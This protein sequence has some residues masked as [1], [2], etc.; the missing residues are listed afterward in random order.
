MRAFG[1]DAS[2]SQP[3]R[4]YERSA[5]VARTQGVPRPETVGQPVAFGSP[6]VT[7]ARAW[8]NPPRPHADDVSGGTPALRAQPSPAVVKPRA[9]PHVWHPMLVRNLPS[10]S[11]PAARHAVSR[12]P[13]FL[14]RRLRS[15]GHTTL[16]LFVALASILCLRAPAADLPPAAAPEAREF[17][18]KK[19]RPVLVEHCYE[20]H[21]ATTTKKLGA[22]LR[23]DSRAALLKGGESGPALVPGKPEESLLIRAV[24][25]ADKEFQMPPKYQLRAAQIADL[26]AWVKMGAP[27]PRTATLADAAPP[28]PKTIDLAA[29]RQFWAFQPIQNPP[30]PKVRDAHWPRTALDQFILADLE[31][32]GLAP[33]PPADKR[34]LLRR[35]TF[36]LIGLPPTPAEAQAFLA[37][38]APQAF[39]RVVERLLASPHYGERWGRHWLDVA[40]YTDSNG[41][42]ENLAYA[43]AYRYR[44]YVIRAFNADKPYD[45]FLHEQLA[46]DLLPENPAATET[47]KFDPLIATGFLALGGK[48]LAEDDPLKMEMDIIDE[49]VDTTSRALLGL[50]MGCAR[51]HDHKFDPIPTEDYYSLTGIFKSTKT[52]ENFRVVAVWHE[53]K[54]ATPEALALNKAHDDLIAR[55]TAEVQQR[56][57]AAQQEFL[58]RERPKAAQYLL[59]A[60]QS[61]SHAEAPRRVP[62]PAPLKPTMVLDAKAA[63][64]GALLIE[65]ENFTRGT[66]LKRGPVILNKGG[67]DYFN[68][69]EYD[70]EITNADNHQLELLY[71]STGGRFFRLFL[72]GEL[73]NAKAVTGDTGGFADNLVRWFAEDIVALKK[74]RHT[75]RIEQTGPTPHLDQI[76][77]V[78]TAAPATIALPEPKP[79]FKSPQQLAREHKLNEPILQRWIAW[80]REQKPAA[81]SVWFPALQLHATAPATVGQASS[82]P[83][84]AASVPPVP[85]ADVRPGG[86]RNSGLGSPENRQ[87][88]M[89]AAHAPPSVPQ[90]SSPASSGGVSPPVPI[91]SAPHALFTAADLANA[92]T[93]TTRYTALFAD[94]AT[95]QPATNGAQRLDIGMSSYFAALAPLR[96][97]LRDLQGPFQVPPKPERFYTDAAKADLKRLEKEQK[98]LET[99]RP[100]LPAA[101]GVREGNIMNLKV[102]LRGNYLT[103][104]AETPRR[105]PRVLAGDHPPVIDSTRSGR[106]E[107][108]R[109]LTQPEHPLTARVMVNRLWHWHFGAGIVRS[110]DNFGRLGDRP[111]HP[112]LLDHLARE[113]MRQGWS[114]KAMHRL[115]MLSSTY[116]MSTTTSPATLAADPEN[117]LFSRFNRRRLEAEEVRDAILVMGGTLAPQ[118]GGQLMTFKNRQYVTGVAGVGAQAANYDTPRRSVYLPVLRSAVY[119]VMQAFDFGDP[120]V[121]NG[122]R[123]STTVAPQALFM[124]NHKLVATS[125]TR[126]ADSLLA[127]AE[128][129]DTERIHRAYEQTVSRPPTAAETTRLL[130]FLRQAEAQ[131]G[132]EPTAPEARRRLLW[133]SLCRVLMAANEFVYLE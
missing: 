115:L 74:G 72:D 13:S 40:R 31:A 17:F 70:F 37:D 49:Q 103:Q 25:Y 71:T 69:A 79:G 29:G 65:A 118:F 39:A 119:D 27:D 120:S 54:L 59:A 26:T 123:S 10:P 4:V 98:D 30:P 76:A 36:D 51:C 21:S 80:L 92:A 87:A 6:A 56:T 116:Q 107:F 57:V 88:R 58:D 42:D 82:L 130:A 122:E 126:L 63:P 106:L 73:L 23:L 111:T 75:L 61:V 128:L 127:A 131:L 95:A 97:A 113:F 7:F 33:A 78:P 112:A 109:W 100:A 41:L 52:M 53:H 46:G 114:L 22:G 105:F 12:W 67:E 110:T 43:N 68:E 38:T 66:F 64:P 133:R 84:R 83:V 34:T 89:P 132:P 8:A 99:K 62:P 19:I 91:P 24:R 11:P 104:G 44:D 55:K 60:A 121:I 77:F 5:G 125:A 86:N 124:M 108:A 101:M 93:L 1:F 3:K 48:M 9:H 16:L 32:K 85:T 50:T 14:R 117:K 102:H 18:E 35:A 2:R 15:P 47:E 96:A 81:D 28:Q 129:A 90:A 94:A 20:C 45:R